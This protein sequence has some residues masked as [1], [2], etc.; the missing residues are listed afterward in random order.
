MT[1]I[2]NGVLG[3]VLVGLI[4]AGVTWL[5]ADESSVTSIV[6]DRVSGSR[7][8]VSR[9]MV[10]ASQV[11]YGGF[12]GGLLVAL[13]LLVVGVLAVPPTSGDALGVA[14]AWST[15]LFGLVIV[16]WRLGIARSITRPQFVELLVFH[17]VYGIG[18]GIWIR[19]T[20]IT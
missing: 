12:A 13:E 3:G 11:A 1:T 7:A 16:S 20:W 4:A 8:S 17:L 18:L 19:L 5:V 6:L 15:L 10:V 14:I 2:L 9:W